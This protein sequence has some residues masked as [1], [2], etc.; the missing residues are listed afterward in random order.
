MIISTSKVIIRSS[1]II[2]SLV[3]QNKAQK[4]EFLY[5]GPHLG[6]EKK[7]YKIMSHKNKYLLR[8]QLS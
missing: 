3:F 1:N 5:F 7:F 2:I 6:Q 4:F 8:N